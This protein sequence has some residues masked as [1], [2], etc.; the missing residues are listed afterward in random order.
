LTGTPDRATRDSPIGAA[1]SDLRLGDSSASPAQGAKVWTFPR[2][3]PADA[4]PRVKLERDRANLKSLEHREAELV[5]RVVTLKE[6]RAFFPNEVSGRQV[7][8][9]ETKL[10]DLRV[11]IGEIRVDIDALSPDFD[12]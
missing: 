12:W 2:H 7:A 10:V 4:T 8:E 3:D 5:R 9:L 6:R 1:G 11:Q